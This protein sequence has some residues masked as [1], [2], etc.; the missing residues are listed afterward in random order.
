VWLP[1]FYLRKVLPRSDWNQETRHGHRGSKRESIREHQRGD[2]IFHIAGLRNRKLA[3][4]NNTFSPQSD[5]D[6]VNVAVPM[7]AALYPPTLCPIVTAL[8]IPRVAY[9]FGEIQHRN[10]LVVC[11]QGSRW[12]SLLY[13][14]MSFF[15]F[16]FKI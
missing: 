4:L 14:R 7:S 15:F 1:W 3:Y 2:D 16:F 12:T 10:D 8:S 13:F 9:S 6:I 11:S 5:R